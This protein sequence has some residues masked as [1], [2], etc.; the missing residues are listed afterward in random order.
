[1]R[2]AIVNDSALALEALRRSIERGGHTLAWVA[3]DGQQA[4]EACRADTPHVL[5]MDLN[6][7]VMNGVECTRRIMAESPCAILIVTATVDGNYSAVYDAMGAGALA[8]VNTPVL[9]PR[10]D[11]DGDQAMLAKIDTV[12]RLVRQRSAAPTRSPAPP[13]ASPPAQR[14]P[15][16]VA[17][18]AS[19]G[20]PQALVE[21]LSQMPPAL[22]AAIV[23][24]Q[25]VDEEFAHGL[26]SWL[27][28]RSG[29]AVE[30]AT[31]GRR[32]EAGVALVAA[33]NDHLIMGPDG[34]LLYTPN[35]RKL[36]FRPSVD[37]FF[38]SAVRYWTR[39]SI[40]V[41]LTGMGRD[42]AAGL[43]AMRQARWR[44]IAQDEASSVVYG[45][46]KAAA[47]AGAVERVLPLARI[48]RAI[49]DA[50][51]GELAQV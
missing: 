4:I 18:G 42:G 10:G 39:R 32:P 22:G 33:T 41:V 16:L 20:G 37:V 50:V 38:L 44:T 7:P 8:A 35:P 11:L 47:E 14:L 1:V 24:I 51:A 19:T 28:E 2:I 48:P 36:P 21:L 13:P 9:G 31:A 43:L 46:P 17:I 27:R 40:G 49:L 26:V 12:G 34:R 29:F 15:P 30:V 23:I 6:M 3:R 45:M 25:H 5:L